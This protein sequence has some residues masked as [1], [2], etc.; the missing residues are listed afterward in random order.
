MVSE[1]GK[2]TLRP[3]L[4]REY[5]AILNEIQARYKRNI[6]VIAK[7]EGFDIKKKGNWNRAAELWLAKNP[8]DKLF[9]KAVLLAANLNP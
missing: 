9:K 3:K 7:D 5:Q 8:D 4:G 1:V 6:K 2:N